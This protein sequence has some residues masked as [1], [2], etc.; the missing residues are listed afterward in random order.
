MMFMAVGNRHDFHGGWQRVCFSGFTSLA[1]AAS[2]TLMIFMAV[3][4]R[5]DFHWS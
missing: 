1:A 4:N 3:A 2:M 5:H